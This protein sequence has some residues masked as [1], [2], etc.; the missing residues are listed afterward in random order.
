[1]K[2]LTPWLGLSPRNSGA[3]LKPIRAGVARCCFHQVFPRVTAQSS[4]GQVAE[5]MGSGRVACIARH[6]PPLHD[7]ARGSAD[8]FDCIRAVELQGFSQHDLQRFKQFLSVR[9]LTIRAWNFFDP[10]DPP[11]ILLFRDGCVVTGFHF[12]ISIFPGPENTLR[13]FIVQRNIRSRIPSR[14]ILSERYG[15]WRFVAIALVPD[16][17]RMRG[18][19][20]WYQTGW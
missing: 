18:T 16:L 17:C 3:S 12:S 4:W 6:L 13:K 19:E 1:M 2:H 7:I 10:S 5:F 9:L 20:A 11:M 14:L 15:N 8:N